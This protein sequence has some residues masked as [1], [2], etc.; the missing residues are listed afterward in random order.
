MHDSDTYKH[1]KVSTGRNDEVVIKAGRRDDGADASSKE[2]AGKCAQHPSADPDSSQEEK[3]ATA[4][5]ATSSSS[6]YVPTT[7][8]DLKT[9]K[10]SKVQIAVI[11]LAVIAIAAFVVWYVAF[12]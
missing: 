10:M 6:E 4:N 7:L 8:E 2:G 5:A 3:P 11:A 1:I 12:S 9:S